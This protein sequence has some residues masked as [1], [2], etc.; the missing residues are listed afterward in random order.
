MKL[1]FS[2][3]YACNF[4]GDFVIFFIIKICKFTLFIIIAVFYID[5][6]L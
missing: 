2:S 6:F 5:K 3:K 4:G 1:K